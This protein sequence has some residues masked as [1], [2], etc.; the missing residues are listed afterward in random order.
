MK[1]EEET[2]EAPFELQLMWSVN[3]VNV[4]WTV[5]LLQHH[6]IYTVLQSHIHSKY[7]CFKLKMKLVK[8]SDLTTKDKTG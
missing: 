5:V 6:C 7:R 2:E 1:N 4:F 3:A 8:L